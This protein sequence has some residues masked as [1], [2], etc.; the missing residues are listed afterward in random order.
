[1]KTVLR[2]SLVLMLLMVVGHAQ[3]I[4]NFDAAPADTNYW[5]FYAPV[6]EGGLETNPSGHYAIST[7]ADPALGW[8]ETSYVTDIVLEGD[9]AMKIDYSV[10]NSESWGGYTKLHH[11]YPDSLSTGTYDWSMYDS[12]SFSYYNVTP[13]D[14]LGRVH[15]RLN[16]G[17]YGDIEDSTYR[18]LGEWYYSFHYILDNEPGWNTVNMALSESDEQSGTAFNHTGWAGVPG[19]LT[20]DKDRIKA[21]AF[22]F[23]VSGS[24]D[25]DVVTGSIIVDDFKLTGSRNALENPG[26]EAVDTQD[27][28]FGWGA[29]AADWAGASAGIVE[30]AEVARTGNSY[31]KVSTTGGEQWAVLYQEN[32][33][34]HSTGETWVLGAWIKDIS[35]DVT[36]GSSA[37]I[38]FEYNDMG[39]SYQHE[40][41]F[42][43]VTT[44]WQHFSI[45][46]TPPADVT[47]LKACVLSQTWGG[48]PGDYAFDDVYLM[49]LGNV[50]TVGPVAV[51]NVSAL[52]GANLNLVTWEDVPGE[53]G[54]SYTVYASPFPIDDLDAAYVDVVGANILEG[55][56]TVAHYLYAPLNDVSAETYY[57]VVAT[58]ASLN[59]GATG[60][61][62]SSYTN[63]ALGIPTIS[64]DAPTNFVADGSL[65]EWDGYTPIYMGAPNS[66]GVSSIWGAVD[67][68]DDCSAN[69]YLAMDD[70]YLYMAADVID[71]V[72]AGYTG[73]GNW[74]EMDAF[75]LFFG[76]Y[77]QRGPTHNALLRGN[78]PDYGLVFTN[79]QYMRDNDGQYIMGTHNDGM[80]YFEA[81]NPDYVIEAKISLDSLAMGSGFTDARF[82]P[83]NGLRLAIEPIIHDNDGGGAWEG[84]VQSSPRNSDNA[85]QTPSVWTHTFIGDTD[86]LDVDEIQ[87]PGTYVLNNNYP[88]PFNPNTVISY[89][90][91]QSENVRLTVYNVLGQEVMTLVN[92]VQQAGS[93]EINFQAGTLASGIYMYRLEAGNFSSTHKMILMK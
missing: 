90:I 28:G 31:G 25:G 36:E 93:H 76:L 40:V 33:V 82:H 78:E 14:S 87:T 12:L 68:D 70:D 91:G 26:F 67:S 74:W 44:E 52:P 57:A 8:I 60:F 54:E 62:P 22:E 75:Q 92:E 72:Y 65:S 29:S 85:W 48:P 55:V 77:D 50:D 69:L 56:Q 58:D 71:D 73:E 66:W 15:L 37:G 79:D 19:N 49:N 34:A 46:V 13:Q 42:P 1:M 4:N 18:D 63:T 21:F 11:Y 84:N 17:D 51:N 80:Y 7:S 86:A 20:L 47:S 59:T 24:G 89:T 43:D 30:D 23:S 88:N 83:M 2:L 41:L 39:A 38:K 81:F 32:N 64:L 9:A 3:V 35:A 6:T 27:E 16:M 10:H 61:S 5:E 45:T 53:E